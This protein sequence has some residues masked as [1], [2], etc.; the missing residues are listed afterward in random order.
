M[1]GAKRRKINKVWTKTDRADA[2][3]AEQNKSEQNGANR[4]KTKESKRN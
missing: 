1:N 4:R 3:V 2:N